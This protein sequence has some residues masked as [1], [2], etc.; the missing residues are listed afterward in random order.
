MYGRSLWHPVYTKVVGRRT[1]ADVYQRIGK[2]ADVKLI[3]A[4]KDAGVVYPPSQVT[5]V[6]LKEKRTIEVW[7]EQ[8]Q[9]NVLIKTYPFTGFSG[10][11]G[12]KLRSGDMQIP[13]GHYG[14]E[15]LNPNSSYYLSMKIDY[16]NE[17]D[18]LK[19]RE[20]GRTNLG[21]DIFIHGKSATIGC[22]PVGDDNIE[23]LFTLVYRTGK[24]NVN[25][26]IA[27]YDMRKEWRPFSPSDPPW[28]GEKYL[29]IKL[30]LAE[31]K[32]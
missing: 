2:V 5:I 6:A 4:F 31:Y 9:K 30:A 10:K 14:I 7:A 28:L 8:D 20:D 11:L 15:Y 29:M 13:E 17:F 25:V 1:Q 23:E 16:P 32:Y 24:D 18:Q 21:G 3:K 26:I 19:A 12:P 27:P 22:I